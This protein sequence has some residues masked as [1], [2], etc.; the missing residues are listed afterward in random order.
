V[1]LRQEST[2]PGSISRNS[3]SCPAAGEELGLQDAVVVRQ[4][5]SGLTD[6]PLGACRAEQLHGAYVVAAP[7]WVHRRAGVLLHQVTHTKATEESEA[8]SPTGD[9][10]TMRIGTQSSAFGFIDAPA[11][12]GSR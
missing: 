12:T 10:P 1:G 2:P 9:P 4:N 3:H 7:P 8:D 6:L 11:R 5:R